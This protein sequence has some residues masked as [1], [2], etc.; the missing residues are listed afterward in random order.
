MFQSLRAEE[1][2][3][4]PLERYQDMKNTMLLAGLMSC[5]ISAA[6][7]QTNLISDGGFESPNG[8]LWWQISGLGAGIKDNP[9]VAYDGTGYLALGGASAG[10]L[11]AAYQTI[12]LPANTVAA[13]LSYY[14]DVYSSSQNSSD[15]L[16]VFIAFANGTEAA[17]VDEETGA[18]SA[19]GEG[20]G[21]YQFMTFDLTPW[22]GQT[23]EIVF[24]ALSSAET[25]FNIDDVAVWVETTADIPSNDYFT[26]RTDLTGTSVTV[27]GNNTFATTEPGEPKIK[28]FPGNNSLWWSWTAASSGTLS[29]STYA[30][31]FPNLLAVYTGASVTSL[32][33]VAAAVSANESGNPAQLIFPVNAGTQY[34]IAVD[35]YDGSYGS[36]ELAL[37]FEVDA[38]PPAVSFSSPA[39]NATLTNS[40]VVVKGTA[41]DNVAVMAVEY[42]LENVAGTNA[43]Q[44]ATGTNN[45]S[46]TITNLLPGLNTVRVFA[47]D[48]SSNLSPTKARSFTY[49]VVMPLLLTTNGS[50]T[51]KLNSNSGTLLELNQPYTITAT[52]ANGYIFANWTDNAGNILTNTAKY[53]FTMTAGLQ[54]EAN[55]VTNRFPS[56]AGTYAGLF[57]DTDSF[58]PAGAGF[59]SAALTGKGGLT[60]QLQLAG[61][62]YRFSGPL[63]PSGAYSNSV[64]GPGGK[65]L[66]LQ[67]QLDLGGSQGLTG[68]VSNSA[69]SA[70]LT[71][72]LAVSKTGLPQAGKK[73]TLVMPGAVDPSTGPG[74]YSFG[75]LSVNTSG[76][77]TFSGVLG[78]GTKVTASSAVVGS[79]RWPLYLSPAA[80]AGEGL[81]WGW[82]GFPT[83]SAD[84]ET[85]GSLSWLKQRGAPATL[86]P[87]GFVFNG[88]VPVMESLYSYTSGRRVL[89]WTNG[90]LELDWGN[91][92]PGLTN[93]V[94]LGANNKLS[95]TNKLS[96]TLTTASGL[97]QG[98]VP[99]GGKNNISVSG[100]LLQGNNAGYGLFLSPTNS[101]SVY[102]GPE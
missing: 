20:P 82:V 41:K 81:V 66:T 5:V 30:S 13:T 91:S 14:Y 89:N 73:Y 23:I 97:F 65:P 9:A 4:L 101:G 77:V 48:T 8:A 28:G 76:T 22:T 47:I 6:L 60:A 93:A 75:T 58:S 54:L 36:V 53:S 38:T 24:Q 71:A 21:F 90:L 10:S 11:Q 69:W 87:N 19:G 50:G 18:N 56:L 84:A 94:M 80:Y 55:F 43:Y 40:T 44:P 34:Q 79:G 39:A 85:V 57:A 31:S 64:A 72:Y 83:N 88:G 1:R 92:S 42:R 78:D 68:T 15:V 86:Y 100:V 32:T 49:A 16:G 26:N 99:A 35:G 102:L 7:G 96:L 33:Q 25:F 62:T 29:L 95:G 51:L 59:F 63:L 37:A 45:W 67:L 2:Q 17:Q 74:G 70:G 61:S 46:A 98:T 52:P 3:V 27:Q 12:T